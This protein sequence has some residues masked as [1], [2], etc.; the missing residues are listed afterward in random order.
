MR[1]F[2]VGGAVRDALIGEPVSER[3]WVVVGATPERM[4]AL[5]YAQLPGGFPVFTHPGSGE[6]YA[7]ARRERK[8]G[9]GHRG[10]E[11]YCGPDVTLEEDLARRDLTVNAIARDESGRFVDPFAGRRDIGRCVL[12]HVGAA[13]VDDPLRLLRAARFCARLAHRGFHLAPDTAGLLTRMGRDP[14]LRTLSG[15]RIWRET[16]LALAT[17]T[18]GSYFR[19]LAECGALAVLLPELAAR[20]SQQVDAT[21]ARAAQADTSVEERLCV[22]LCTASGQDAGGDPDLVGRTCE[23]LRVP[24]ALR[25]FA[26]R[27]SRHAGGFAR[28]LHADAAGLLELVEGLEGLRDP[29]HF[30]TALRVCKLCAGDGGA[31]AARVSR[32]AAA[33]CTIS[34]ATLGLDGASGP[35]VGEALRAARLAA[36]EAALA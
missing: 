3:D 24:S 21:L 7:L 18:P 15:E 14:E 35:A 12:R 16:S 27:I 22:L 26:E 11:V 30:R 10:F 20:W 31:T 6:E 9:E 28:A 32:A 17:R 25:R 8:R 4:R 23:R 33:A 1:I 13:F 34:A 5:G 36:I 2:L 29:Q 19:V